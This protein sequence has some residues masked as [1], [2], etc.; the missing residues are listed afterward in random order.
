MKENET[1]K[2]RTMCR[3]KNEE[4]ERSSK[5]T[6]Y[7]NSRYLLILPRN[8]RFLRNTNFHQRVQRNSATGPHP[9]PHYICMRLENWCGPATD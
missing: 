9:G 7:Y 4:S 2:E 5:L 3:N 8:S 1:I 6:G